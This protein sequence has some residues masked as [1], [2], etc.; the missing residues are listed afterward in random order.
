MENQENCAECLRLTEKMQTAYRTDAYVQGD[1][2]AF[3]KAEAEYQAHRSSAH[4]ES[5]D[6][7]LAG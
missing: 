4:P 3:K 1:H 6:E 7:R 5:I 2:A